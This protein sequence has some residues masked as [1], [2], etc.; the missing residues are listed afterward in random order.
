MTDAFKSSPDDGTQRRIGSF[1]MMV[2]VHANTVTASLFMTGSGYS[3]L[4]ASMANSNAA[5]K[6]KLTW[7]SWFV[8][9][10]VPCIA[11]LLLAPLVLYV[12]YPP[13]IKSTPE[14]K[15]IAKEALANMGPLGKKEKIVLCIFP[16]MVILW[17]TPVSLTGL[18][19]TSVAILGVA[20]LLAAGVLE[21]SHILT[22]K[23]AYSTLLWFGV[24]VM[25]ANELKYKGF[26]QWTADHLE[27]MAGGLPTSAA[28]AFVVVFFYY[29]HYGF[30][31]VT[32]YVAALYPLLLDAMIAAKVP[33][34]I[35]ARALICCC[36]SSALMPYTSSVN[37][38]FYELKYVPLKDWITKSLAVSVVHLG[39]IFSVGI[40]WWQYLGYGAD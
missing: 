27:R 6:S 17:M 32:A 3:A 37:P 29:V 14:A 8:D 30:A 33:G 4:M 39:V 22:D 18:D 31:S 21:V 34:D 23:S 7:F 13:E 35:A 11:D 1:L 5:V 28:F 25:L 20:A 38:P 12:V 2:A 19:P 15:G 9:F 40:L 36:F 16:V 10:S 24:L 26:F